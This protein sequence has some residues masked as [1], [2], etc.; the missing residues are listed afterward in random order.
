MNL[1]SELPKMPW[2][3]FSGNKHITTLLI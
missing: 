1:V 3:E 2:L